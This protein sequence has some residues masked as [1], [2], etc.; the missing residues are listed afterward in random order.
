MT[1][2]PSETADP[3]PPPT[4]PEGADDPQTLLRSLP[5]VNE[6]LDAVG[7]AELEIAP[8]EEW[9]EE[10]RQALSDLRALVDQRS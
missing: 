5:P 10:V 9:V 2:T 3:L 4:P 7:N 6:V 8:R 1:D